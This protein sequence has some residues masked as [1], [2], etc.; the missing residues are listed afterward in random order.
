M[1]TFLPV[2]PQ[3]KSSLEVCPV[4]QS[5]AATRVLNSMR[6]FFLAYWLTTR[7]R[8]Q[9]ICEGFHGRNPPNPFV[10]FKPSA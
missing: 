4:Y 3:L 10:V 6:I 9:W 1:P 2:F 5:R 8:A 7:L